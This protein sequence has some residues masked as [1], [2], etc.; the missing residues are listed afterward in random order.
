MKRILTLL[1]AGMIMLTFT[2]C[3]KAT[4]EEEVQSFKTVEVQELKQEVM[5]VQIK[6]T[7]TVKADVQKSIAFKSGGKISNVHVSKG[8]HIK[9]GQTLVSLDKTDLSLQANGSKSK[10]DAA[11]NDVKKTKDSYE[12]QND[13]FTKVEKLYEQK[14]ISMDD[15]NKARLS[16][17]S[18]EA[19]YNQAVNQ[20][21]AM[22]QD[23]ENKLELLSDATIKS[24]VEGYVLD[25]P[26]EKGEM[27]GAGTPVVTIRNDKNIV[28]TGIT[29]EDLGNVK[30]GDTVTIKLKDETTEGVVKN[31][32]QVP[33]PATRTYDVDIAIHKDY[34]LESIVNITFDIG[35]ENGMWI[36]IEA[37]LSSNID[38]VYVVEE[39]K[40]IRKTVEIEEVRGTLVKV[41]GLKANDKLIIRGMKSVRDGDLVKIKEQ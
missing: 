16:R 17:D 35:E 24:D 22:K 5:P 30:V 34:P 29:Q 10:L 19:S 1:M 31:I 3:D 11:A 9:P 25:V 21:N 4:A 20:Y 15:Y 41:K 28:R 23:Y 18:A 13:Y 38:Y 6:Y 26:Y 40:V 12:Y 27:V 37:I 2:G 14:A 8:D 7:G 39:D 36:P 32:G 33:D